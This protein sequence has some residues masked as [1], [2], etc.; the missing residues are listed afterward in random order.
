MAVLPIVISGCGGPFW[1]PDLGGAMRLAAEQ[2]RMVLVAYWSPFNDGCARM[3]RD[4]FS[5]KEVQETMLE[6]ILVRLNASTNR[7]F[8]EEHG[9]HA[10]PSF[11]IF[12]PDGRTLR[13]AQGFLNEG[14]FRGFIQAARLSM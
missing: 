7:K 9:L 10:V 14:R 1:R 8:A 12:A 2:R 13:V 11:V 5:L 4:V 6:T 3:E